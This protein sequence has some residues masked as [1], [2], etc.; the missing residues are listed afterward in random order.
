MLAYQYGDETAFSILYKRHS[1]KIYGYLIK[2]LGDGRKADDVFQIT[3]LKLH[4]SRSLYKSE[5]PFLAWA[6][7]ICKS[8][9]A[10]FLRAQ[11]RRPEIPVRHLPETIVEGSAPLEIAAMA[12][13]SDQ[14]RS[15]IEMRFR[16]DLSFEDIAK[17]INKSPTNVRQL[18]SRAIRKLRSLK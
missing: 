15:L 12:N 10:D 17:R 4:R 9:L 14:Q 8:C 13:L 11:N 2:Q 1:A 18:V 7:T 5:F 16:D 3:F 6:F